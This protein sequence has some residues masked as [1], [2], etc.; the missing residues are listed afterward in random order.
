MTPEQKLQGL[1]RLKQHE[2]PPDGYFDDF[3]ESFHQRQRQELMNRG[4][5]S[6][7]WER[8]TTSLETLS[9]PA[10][11]WGA[12]AAYGA[13]M[14][15]VCLWPKPSHTPS[16]VT[17]LMQTNNNNNNAAPGGNNLPAPPSP[18]NILPASGKG[19]SILHPSGTRQRSLGDE[20]TPKTREL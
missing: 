6:L 2:S 5:L 16:Q 14:L 7:L 4:A 3:L 12:C 10:V 8:L 13:V 15:L 1:L 11:I 9:R 17:I 18:H 20:A 19:D